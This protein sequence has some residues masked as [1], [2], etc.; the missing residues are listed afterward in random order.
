[1]ALT[2]NVIWTPFPSQTNVGV[3][4][5]RSVNYLIDLFVFG[6]SASSNLNEVVNVR[7]HVRRQG[8]SI[9]IKP[10][11]ESTVPGSN[12]ML[13]LTVSLPSTI[14]CTDVRSPYPNGA[15]LLLFASPSGSVADAAPAGW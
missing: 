10:C 2:G 13:N 4:C 5:R 1:M 6:P 3:S 14:T 9:W 8:I 11:T 12:W 7:I 15:T